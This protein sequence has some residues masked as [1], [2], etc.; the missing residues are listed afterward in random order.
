MTVQKADIFELAK[1]D[2]GKFKVHTADEAYAFC[3]RLAKSHYENFPVG[4]L[5]IPKAMR[6]HFFAIYAYSRAA[7]DFADESGSKSDS[8]LALASFET[9]LLHPAANTGNP[10]F[11]ALHLTKAKLN[12]PD[13]P[14]LKLLEAFRR[15]VDFRQAHDFD[16]LMEYCSF[17]ANP[18][19]ELVLRI[20]GQFNAE[21][22]PR[23]DEICSA[24]QLVN[25]WQDISRD[26][27]IGRVYIPQSLLDKYNLDFENL[28]IDEKSSNFKLLLDELF[29]K[30]ESLFDSGEILISLTRHKRLRA[31]LAFIIEGGRLIL[32]KCR[33]SGT[34]LYRQRPNISKFEFFLLMGKVI[35]KH[36]IIF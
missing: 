9:M 30:T 23:S 15:D 27:A 31:E 10:I 34:N 1:P 3:F 11:T 7:D 22:A 12:I 29:C 17:S 16:E 35:F 14:F 33:K 18:V 28:A 24:L 13:E 5:L 2:G 26:K 19:G 20:F 25:F 36:K 4:S 32:K 8:L 21:T 6:P